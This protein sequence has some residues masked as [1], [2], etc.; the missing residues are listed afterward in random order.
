MPVA[1]YD[2]SQSEK[3]SKDEL[4]TL[5]LI[6]DEFCRNLEASISNYLRTVSTISIEGVA[7]MPFGQFS[8]A[9]SNPTFLA[10][11]TLQPFEGN[12]IFELSLNLLYSFV[13]RLLGGTVAVA[14]V[15]REPTEIEQSVIIKIIDRCLDAFKA[16]WEHFV[17]LKPRIESKTTN[18]QFIQFG[19]QNELVVQIKLALKVGDM[20]GGATIAMPVS[21]VKALLQKVSVQ[22]WVSGV[23]KNGGQ[24]G[25]EQEALL[26]SM[27]AVK[28]PVAG[29]MGNGRIS[30]KQL[31]ALKPGDIVSIG[32]RALSQVRVVVKDKQKFDGSAGLIGNKKGIKIIQVKGR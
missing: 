24:G 11:L 28:V 20:R 15:G 3:I 22:K 10:V 18:P 12:L 7:Q 9:L 26:R 29:F 19:S 25:H 27:F 30:L 1:A 6:H 31:V 2:F 17:V 14:G 21:L 8:R 13:D 5:Q 32:E 4:R 23:E 16:A